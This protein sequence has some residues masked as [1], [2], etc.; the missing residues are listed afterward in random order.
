MSEGSNYE[1]LEEIWF[2]ERSSSD[3]V[4]LEP[5]FF[6]GI[7]HWLE[8]L[9]EEAKSSDE[10]LRGVLGAEVAIAE[11]MISSLRVIRA[12]KAMALLLAE[13][14]VEGLTRQELEFLG[15][16]VGT[17]LERAPSPEKRRPIE[18]GPKL[19]ITFKKVVSA[20][21]GMD[22]AVYGPFS[23]GDVANIPEENA[24]IL[25]NKGLAEVIRGEGS[26]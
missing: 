14:K 7:G 4:P 24:K 25:V 6:E 16:A 19:L 8:K 12:T 1:K 3:L 13:E 15:R 26:L 11:E 2:K 9:R 21:V 10:P 22:L 23:E 17:G 20:F 18:G 5:D